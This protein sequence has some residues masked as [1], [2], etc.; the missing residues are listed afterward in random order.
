M[1]AKKQFRKKWNIIYKR[2]RFSIFDQTQII[3]YFKFVDQS[4]FTSF[5]FAVFI[6]S[7]NSTSRICF[8]I[9]QNARILYIAFETNFTS[10]I[11]SIKTSNLEIQQRI[12]MRV[13]VNSSES[14]YI[15]VVDID[16]IYRII[17]VE[18][19]LTNARK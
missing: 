3:N 2:M 19:S 13:S 18:T 8:S 16:F 7:F 1:I 10:L 4:D 15:V 14:K 9:N 6:N 17:R 11:K 12:K 5:K